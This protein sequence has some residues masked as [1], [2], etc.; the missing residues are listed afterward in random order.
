[1]PQKKNLKGQS[2]SQ[3]EPF[4]PRTLRHRVLFVLADTDCWDSLI[5]IAYIVD[6][7][8]HE[9]AYIEKLGLFYLQ[10]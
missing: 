1:M 3:V 7:I 8:H 4:L 2:D 6:L 5:V 9:M 10:M